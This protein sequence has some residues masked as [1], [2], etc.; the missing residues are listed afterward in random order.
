MLDTVPGTDQNTVDMI[1]ALENA[2][3]SKREQTDDSKH[4]FCVFY[5]FVLFYIIS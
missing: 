4:A 1:L 2:H 3:S 5:G